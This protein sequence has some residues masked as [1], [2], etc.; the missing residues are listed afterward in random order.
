MVGNLVK[1]CLALK[2]YDEAEEAVRLLID[3]GYEPDNWILLG[4]ILQEKKRYREAVEAFKKGLENLHLSE[5]DLEYGVFPVKFPKEL[6]AFTALIGLAECCDAMGDKAESSRY[7]RRASK[8]RSNSPKPH[9]GMAYHF[10]AANQLDEV[11]K[12]LRRM[13]MFNSSKDPDV[14]RVMGKYCYRKGDLDL[15]F[16]CYLKAVEYG[17]DDEANIDPLYSVGA[18]LGKWDKMKTVL[19]EFLEGSPYSLKAMARLSSIYFQLEQYTE[20][21]E[22]VRKGLEL[23]PNNVV[24]KGIAKK[25]QTALSQMETAGRAAF[26]TGPGQVAQILQ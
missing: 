9:I 12:V 16:A 2:K 10:M 15:A 4:R 13:A 26:E 7:Y 18:S 22:L 21:L 17:K 25:A 20:A 8:L 14:Q 23:E 5:D 24:L 6:D 3:R 11:E 1:I 19:E